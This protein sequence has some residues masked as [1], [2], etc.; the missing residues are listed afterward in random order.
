MNQ[1]ISVKDKLPLHQQVVLCFNANNTT[2]VTIFLDNAEV[3]KRLR[4]NG[5]NMP[6]DKSVGYCFASQETK[7][8][9]LNDVTHWMELPNPPEAS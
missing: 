3:Q 2:A 7:S 5:V 6:P 9:T 8:H 1:W 4:L